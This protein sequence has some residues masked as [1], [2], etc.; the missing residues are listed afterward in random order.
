MALTTRTV[1][2]SLRFPTATSSA[3]VTFYPDLAGGDGQ[4]LLEKMYTAALGTSITNATN[5]SPIVITTAAAHGY[6]T[7]DSVTISGVL[8]NTNA[9]GTRTIT[10]ISDTTFSL[11]GTTGN[12]AYISG[13]KAACKTVYGTIALPVKTNGDT[14]GYRIKLP[15]E[16]GHNEH[17]IYLA[18]GADIDL[19]E[20][21]SWTTSPLSTVPRLGD[22]DDVNDTGKVT[23][24]YLRYNGSEWVD[25]NILFGDV[26]SEFWAPLTV[27]YDA[28]S[29]V[30]ISVTD[31][32]IASF[33]V[34]S[35][36]PI[37]Q[38]AFLFNSGITTAYGDFYAK[39]GGLIS[40][41]NTGM[42]GI[43]MLGR[44]GGTNS[45]QAT[46]TP[47]VLTGN[48]TLMLPDENGTVLT[49]VSTISLATTTLVG[50]AA[51]FNMALIDDNFGLISADNIF[52][53]A[54]EFKN[55]KGIVLRQTSNGNRINIVPNA[56]TNIP[57]YG[58]VLTN[59]ALTANR[60]I[61]LPDEDGTILTTASVISLNSGV[62]V[63]YDA[64]SYLQ[65]NVGD[66]GEVSFVAAS[67]DPLPLNAFSFN[68]GM[69]IAGGELWMQSGPII[70]QEGTNKDAV[71]LQGR[72]GG[73]SNYSVVLTPAT[74]S[75]N[76]TLTLPNVTGTVI[77]TGD[78][79]TVTTTILGGDITTAGKALLDD[80]DA[81]AQRTTLG[82]GTMATQA[83]NNVAITGGAIDV[84]TF[85]LYDGAND[86][87][88]TLDVADTLSGGNKS[89]FIDT[90]GGNRSL[91]ITGNATISGTNTGDQTIT[92]T[93]DVTGS[94]TGS[95]ATTI[96]ALKVTNAM[97]AG[98][99]ANSKLTNSSITVNGSSISLGGSATVTASTTNA[100]TVGTGL[101]LSSGTTF[102][103][104]VAKTVSADTSYLATLGTSQT[105]SGAKLFTST[106]ES[107][108]SSSVQ[109]RL[110]YSSVT[111]TDF[112]VDDADNLT[113]T[114]VDAG[115][116]SSSLKN[117]QLN[118]GKVV[119]DGTLT[120]NSLLVAGT[121]YKAT[122]S[123]ASLTSDKTL[124]I[125][126][127]TGT[128]ITTGDT[129][130]VT[131]TMIADGTIVNGDINA[132]A[133][134]A[135][136]KLALTGSIV[137]A[138][139]G[140]SAAIAYSK[141]SLSGSIVNADISASAAI[142]NSKLANS[143]ITV[144]SASTSLGGSV[145]LY[146]G[147]TTLQTSSANQALT[148]ISSVTLPGATSGTVQLIPT[149]AVGTG[150]VLTIP[151]TTGTIITTG[152]TGTV[153]NTML[154]GSIALT[155]LSSSTTTALGVGSIELG[156]AT[157]TTIAR[158]SAGVVSIEGVN[159]VT[160]SSTDTLTNKTLTSP[161]LTT[162]V[163]GT[164]SSGTL[165]NCTG[166]PVSGITAS[167]TTALGVGSIE[168]GH[169]TDTTLSRSSAGVLAVEGVVVPTISSTNTL[170][171][172]SL[173]DSTTYFVDDADSTKKMQFQLSGITTATTRTLTVPNT[174]G[175]IT[176]GTGT[177]NRIGYWSGTNTLTSNANF[178]FD[179]TN[180]VVGTTAADGKAY[181]Y[182][183]TTTA[184]STQT[185][186]NALAVANGDGIVNYGIKS[187]ARC[188]S[189]N[190][191][192]LYMTHYGVYA[193]AAERTNGS[194]AGVGAAIYGVYAKV[195][196]TATS[197]QQIGVYVN[198]LNGGTAYT[199][200]TSTNY[201]I[202]STGALN[203]F[204]ATTEQVRI[205]YDSSNYVNFT[206]GSTGTATI[207]G[208][209]TNKGFAFASGFKLGFF[210]ATA[211]VQPTTSVAGGTFVA[212]SGTAV[213]DAS[214]FD[215][216]TL[217]QI[218]AALRNLGLLA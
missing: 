23:G 72:A 197:L 82:L 78:T 212:N 143:A 146:A 104:S 14:I 10:K 144:N 87:F 178:L 64:D 216:Y 150:T 136:S 17:Y 151:A 38:N 120:C 52:I 46:L 199:T 39:A 13:G 11:V 89:L 176:F 70:A 29:N 162:P 88:L 164:P 86:Y 160:T 130:T 177:A 140:A 218:V 93:G 26:P 215:G 196:A 92:L 76:R 131:S 85:R 83:A 107:R 200:A 6:A 8:G 118:Y 16:T 50:T 1:N 103:G 73:S 117:L 207:S 179:G 161:T 9:N 35:Q 195:S 193:E 54:N 84:G 133:A 2:I 60:T 127:T 165:T 112:T 61:T 214:T 40:R 116:N 37:A 47:A 147:T 28:D 169:A 185:N 128:L 134:I 18:A 58:L 203:V 191:A 94:G 154:A 171:N 49:N 114:P 99:I 91:T 71:K 77:T 57:S 201:G 81:A 142:A 96:G 206:V 101:S 186:L 27:K 182:S 187:L 3:T 45:Y 208:A 125:P 145:T 51:Q 170:T 149:A 102:D 24:N 175:T 62:K 36:D 74:L 189:T 111:W 44:A 4:V 56:A 126:N 210:G 79:G 163:L 181:I 113:I 80:A 190:S 43:A 121:L 124:T 194:N 188:D 132:S 67:Q 110:A 20:L 180:L 184:S 217:K 137:N 167:T 122:F 15:R 173:Q 63:V 75:N 32:G 119:V 213:N 138:D 25:S 155:K 34:A 97:L 22:L 90:D 55:T 48:R 174:D 158:V 59:A 68:A 166:L 33:D 205:A 152:D 100:L 211:I 168:L 198:V 95:F 19:S 157:D 159:I 139:I 21:I 7:G 141:L 53:G 106:V 108:S 115:P 148:G 30:T 153:T 42:D 5:A 109:L 183:S 202:I 12:G 129:G 204:H 65:V 69:T 135:Y 209:G 192:N 41:Y 66:G 98:S 156:H 172:K 31:G 123:T 105:I